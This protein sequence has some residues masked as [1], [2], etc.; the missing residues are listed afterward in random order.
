LRAK[1]NPNQLPLIVPVS[2]WLPPETLPDLRGVGTI[3]VDTEGLDEGISRGRGSGWP[4]RSGYISG[5]AVAW[6]DGSGNTQSLYAPTRHPDSPNLDRERVIA[7]LRDHFVCP[8]LTVVMHHS[9]HD[10]GW[11]GAD[12]GLE[13][14]VKLADTE[15]EAMILDENRYSYRLD[16]LCKWRGLPGMDGNDAVMAGI[17]RLPAR[18]VG[19]YAEQDAI[20]TLELHEALQGGI[21][22][23]GLRDALQLEHDLIPMVY[24]MRRRGIRVDLDHAERKK[25]ELIHKRDEAFLDL[26][27]RLYTRVGMDEIGRTAWLEKVFDEHK[28][29]YP[30]TEKTSRGSFTAGTTGW[31]HKHPH[32]LPQLIVKADKLNNCAT[33]FIQKF[34]LDFAHHGR[35]H[36]QINQFRGEEGGTRTFRFAYSA[37]ALQQ[38]PARQGDMADAFRGSFLPEEGATW[39]S[40]DFSQQEYRLIVHYAALRKLPRAENAAQMYRDNPDTDFHQ[41]VVDW[42]GLDRTSAKNT[43]FAKA[44]RAGVPKFADM[45]GRTEDEA[46]EIYSRYDRELPFVSALMEDCDRLAKNR[47]YLRLL[48]GARRHFDLWSPARKGYGL[49]AK[50]KAMAEEE[51]PG[52]RL[53][54]AGTYKAGNS[55]IQAGAARMTK[56]CMRACWRE[57]LVPLIQMHDELCYS[58]GSQEEALR[59]EELMR[60]TVRLTVPVKVD[61]EFGPNWGDAKHPWPGVPKRAEEP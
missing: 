37:P 49:S 11:F 4:Y 22:A 9:S 43:N 20:A 55:L 16:D 14:P 15:A 60:D 27:S 26:S 58:C 29:H 36:A 31:M 38:A 24:A 50:P 45:I 3:V 5:V 32:W 21:D 42:T 61:A 35:I 8:G 40:L 51:W 53:V 33:K 56:L 23:E 47:G 25:A 12:W 28:I 19:L 59:V 57:G 48:D 13:P 52:E 2:P 17:A 41:L 10:I 1:P 44:Y 6:R 18:Y 30:L 46:R 54:R 7:W 34:I 39:G